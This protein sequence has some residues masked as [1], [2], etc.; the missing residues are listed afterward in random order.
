MSYLSEVLADAPLHYWRLAD[1]G[2]GIA[3]DIG[4]SALHLVQYAPSGESG[5]GYSGPNAD[6]GAWF[7]RRAS[8]LTTDQFAM[9]LAFP[10]SVELCYWSF[11]FDGFPCL[12]GQDD[13]GNTGWEISSGRTQ[14]RILV[15]GAIINNAAPGHLDQRWHHVVLTATALLGSCYIDGALKTTGATVGVAPAAH[16][17]TL[18]AIAGRA[19]T[20]DGFLSEVAFYNTVLSAA[21]VTAHFNALDQIAQ[22]PVWSQSGGF[23]SG[24][25]SGTPVS[26]DLAAIRGAVIRTFPNT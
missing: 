9:P 22:A 5:F 25:G 14:D 16:I 24:T 26:A 15:G 13:T 1:P 23:G 17:L 7:N 2:G 18:G 20:L 8:Q 3:H 12:A 11:G 21:R 4:S 10:F 19:I 6:G